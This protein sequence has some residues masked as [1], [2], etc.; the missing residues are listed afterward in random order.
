MA[1][2]L[3]VGEGLLPGLQRCPH[4]PTPARHPRERGVRDVKSELVSGGLEHAQRLSK[5]GPPRR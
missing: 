5:A 3:I 1:R 2:L 4:L